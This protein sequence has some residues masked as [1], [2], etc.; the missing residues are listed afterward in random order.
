MAVLANAGPSSAPSAGLQKWSGARDLNPGP[1]G[2]ELDGV[3]SNRADFCRSYVAMSDP[4]FLLVQKGVNLRPTYYIK[5][6]RAT[7]GEWAAALADRRSLDDAG[8]RTY[9]RRPESFARP[10]F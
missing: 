5:Y 6:Y 1:H 7:A 10:R 8:G 4:A 2:P 9:G 3:T